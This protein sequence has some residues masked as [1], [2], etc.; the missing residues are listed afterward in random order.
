M[1]RLLQSFPLRGMADGLRAS[2]A[3]FPFRSAVARLVPDEIP[4]EPGAETLTTENPAALEARVLELLR[5]A[6]KVPPG[7]LRRDALAEVSDLRRRAIELHRRT[8]EDLKAQLVAGR[9]NTA[10]R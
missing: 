4:M 2:A 6:S 9:S 1:L 3:K 5:A 10:A 7:L 8:A